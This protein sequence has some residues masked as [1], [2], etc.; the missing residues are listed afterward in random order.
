MFVISMSFQTPQNY[1][2]PSLFSSMHLHNAS[3]ASCIL[4]LFL[5]SVFPES[6]RSFRRQ[7]GCWG[8]RKIWGVMKRWGSKGFG[9]SFFPREQRAKWDREI[10]SLQ[11]S[12]DPAL[13]PRAVLSHLQP[14]FCTSHPPP[15][16]S[17]SRPSATLH[18][19]EHHSLRLEGTL[20]SIH[21]AD[22]DTEAQMAWG[23]RPVSARAPSQARTPAPGP[24]HNP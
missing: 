14:A 13:A 17:T 2:S 15:G 4:L 1:L 22:E 3:H 11:W 9:N 18:S 8:S 7:H 6:D 23:L 10:L 20:D 16:D 5:D 19:L 24:P 12:S 21:F